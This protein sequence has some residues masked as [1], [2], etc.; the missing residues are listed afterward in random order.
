MKNLI[1]ILV[2][3]LSHFSNII[4]A[5]VAINSDGSDPDGSAMLDVKSESRGVLIPRL[6]AVQ[7]NAINNPATGLLVFQTDLSSGLY[8]NTGTASSPNWLQLSSTLIT[9]LTDA[10]GDTKVQ[11]EESADE[12]KI[13]FDNDGSESMI[14]DSDGNVGIGISSPL[15]KLHI[16]GGELQVDNPGNDNELRINAGNYTDYD[17]YSTLGLMSGYGDYNYDL[18]S[19]LRCV[20]TGNAGSGRGY[21]H[22]VFGKAIKNQSDVELMRL[23]TAGNLGIGTSSPDASSLVDISSTS[24][25]FL[26]PRM[27]I[28]ERN[29]ISSP[30]AGLIIYNTTTSRPNIY[31]GTIWKTFDGTWEN[32]GMPIT[33]SGQI[34]N[35]VLIGNQCWMRE[36]LN[37][38]T[39]I[40][41]SIDQTN[42]STIEKYCYYDNNTY[43]DTYGGLYEW[44]EMM[45]YVT[46]E[47]T[48]GICP[49]GWHIPTDDEWKT[50]EGTVDTQY[51]V[52]NPEWDNLS[53]RGFDAGDRLKTNTGWYYSGNGTD[54]FAFSA[55]PGGYS[56]NTFYYHDQSGYWW[57]SNEVSGP[58][59][60]YRKLKY[61]TDQ[62]YRNT[63]S[64]TYGMSVR[65]LKN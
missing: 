24:M 63:T 23:T 51:G 31:N 2:L 16:S 64:K 49:S 29:A 10:D 48:Q 27:S 15:K 33:Y 46:T 12:D 1:C 45:Q 37:V 5:Q 4:T 21:V 65:C 47:G 30:A 40:D 25:G 34:Y 9:Q 28:T 43:C 6:T 44:N 17:N 26:P 32:C 7:R 50:L 57:S 35:T 36:N 39:R 62:V 22:L 52:G 41:G 53:N 56:T 11:V 14:I 3:V 20:N 60:F 42:N 13:R 18:Y 59:A 58:S 61:N 54:V 19:Y 55:L 38:G 8:Y